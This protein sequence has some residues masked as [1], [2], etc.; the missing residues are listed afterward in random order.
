MEVNY[1]RVAVKSKRAGATNL[2]VHDLAA[3]T[4]CPFE[5]DDLV[6]ARPAGQTFR[7]SFAGTLDQDLHTP[8]DQGLVTA[9]GNL[10]H[11]G[12]KPLETL[13]ANLFRDLVR[14][15]CRGRVAPF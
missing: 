14:H 6:A 4:V 9:A 12:Q 10:V 3:M 15:H 8:A 11:Q 2:Q 1:G 5:D 7:V 13:F